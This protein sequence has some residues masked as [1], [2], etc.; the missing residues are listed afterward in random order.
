MGLSDM[1]GIRGKNAAD[2]VADGIWGVEDTQRSSA[3]R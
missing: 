2:R 1:D 3:K